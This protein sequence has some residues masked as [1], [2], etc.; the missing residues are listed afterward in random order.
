[1]QPQI[2]TVMITMRIIS[3]QSLFLRPLRI[4]DCRRNNLLSC[5]KSSNEARAQISFSQPTGVTA[6]A[7]AN[8]Q[9]APPKRTGPY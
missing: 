1:M 5:S 4:F 7:V 2:V 3:R 8:Q 6:S 9:N